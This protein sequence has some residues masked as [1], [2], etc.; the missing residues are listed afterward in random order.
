M[1]EAAQE[2]E[3]RIGRLRAA[4]RGAMLGGD[5]DRARALRAELRAAE[6][7][8]DDLLEREAP[9]QQPLEEPAPTGPLLPLREQ[10]HEALSLLTVP[11][12]PK[13]ISTVHEAFFAVTF[14]GSKLTSL[15][16]DEER[17]FRQAP[18]ARPYYLC[19]AL[20]ADRLSPARGLLAIS[21]WP[22]ERRMI[23]PL[24][25]RVDFLVG[26]IQVAEAVGRLPGEADIT[27]V[28]RLLWRF[29][30]NIP[31]APKHPGTMNPRAVIEAA[32]AELEVHESADSRARQEAAQR[33]RK[34]LDDAELLFGTRFEQLGDQRRSG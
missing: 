31:G 3:Q 11:A 25:P 28:Q 10:V 18:Y 34:Q 4:I 24:S 23:G 29:F 16:R 33:A 14:P 9:A 27:A 5:R 21:T 1:S 12:A 6:Q 8:W 32:E 19:A 30:A 7:T 17:S 26:A 13:L 20:T 15:K 22:A 2:L